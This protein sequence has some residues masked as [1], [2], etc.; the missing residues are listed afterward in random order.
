[1]MTALSSSVCCQRS[2]KCSQQDCIAKL[3]HS[4]L[5]VVTQAVQWT[6]AA[7]HVVAAP[8]EVFL[9]NW[10]LNILFVA[11]LALL[12]YTLVVVAPRQ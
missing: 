3:L 7:L 11:T 12:T 4:T 8:F 9:G 6:A 10:G 1:M 5:Q 2:R